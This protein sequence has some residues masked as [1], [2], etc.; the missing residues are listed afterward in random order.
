MLNDTEFHSIMDD[1]MPFNKNRSFYE[2]KEIFD[3]EPEVISNE[4]DESNDLIDGWW[5]SIPLLN[6]IEHVSFKSNRLIFM[7]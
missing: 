7:S 5:D 6:T 3:S 2:S 1:T 4:W